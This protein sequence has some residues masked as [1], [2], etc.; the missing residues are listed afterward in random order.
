MGLSDWWGTVREVAKALR[1]GDLWST[2]G[3]LCGEAVGREPII[4]CGQVDRWWLDPG[5]PRT[6]GKGMGT[7]EYGETDER[8]DSDQA[9]PLC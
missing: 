2:V 1:P 5:V 3:S 4:G 7:R 6:R 8:R 9:A